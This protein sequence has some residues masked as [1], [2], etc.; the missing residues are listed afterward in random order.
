MSPC[1]GPHVHRDRG[2]SRR[3]TRP[4]HQREAKGEVIVLKTNRKKGEGKGNTT[5]ENR[6]LFF[7]GAAPEKLKKGSFSAING[8]KRR[9]KRSGKQSPSNA[10]I[11]G[12]PSGISKGC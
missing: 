6:H 12:H 8:E 9:E 10:V 5:K 3:V 2:R 7:L 1:G 4:S 11:K